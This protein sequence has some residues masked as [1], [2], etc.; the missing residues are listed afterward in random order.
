MNILLMLLFVVAVVVV[1]YRSQ[2]QNYFISKLDNN[3]SLGISYGATLTSTSAIIGFGGLAGWLGF[4]I[5]FTMLIPMM[6]FIY[7][8]TVYIGPK[9]WQ[10]NQRIQANTYIELIGKY[11]NSPLLSKLLATITVALIPFYCVAVLIGVGNLSQNLLVLTL[12][13]Q[14]QDLVF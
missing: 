14:W 9:V 3:A 13:L 8:A 1:A 10:A 7:L 5:P 2:G 11:Y 4:A 12:L 6:L